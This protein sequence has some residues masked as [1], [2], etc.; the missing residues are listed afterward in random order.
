MHTTIKGQK[1]ASESNK[2]STNVNTSKRGSEDDE[3][4]KMP[5]YTKMSIEISKESTSQNFNV[6]QKILPERVKALPDQCVR[7]LYG[8]LL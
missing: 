8:S 2:V 4:R 6:R 7:M 5:E 3:S 1:R